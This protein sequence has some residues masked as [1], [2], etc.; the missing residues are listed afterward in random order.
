MYPRYSHRFLVWLSNLCSTVSL[1]CIILFPKIPR[2]WRLPIIRWQI[3]FHANLMLI[4]NRYLSLK[5]SPDQATADASSQI[6]NLHCLY[7]GHLLYGIEF[8]VRSSPHPCTFPLNLVQDTL[9]IHRARHETLAVWASTSVSE[10]NLD[11]TTF[12][13]S[14]AFSLSRQM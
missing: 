8:S 9:R 7:R 2:C 6:P 5:N 10:W 12:F 11:I 4:Q 13:D 14:F 1:W 3:F